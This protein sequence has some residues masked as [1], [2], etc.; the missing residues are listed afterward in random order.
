MTDEFTL[1]KQMPSVLR[2]RDF[3]LYTSRGRLVDLWQ[4]GGAAIL[5]HTPASVLREIKNTAERGLYAPFPHFLETRYFKAL[6]KIFPGRS[7]RLYAA[8]PPDLH[9][10]IKNGTAA[11]WRPFLDAAD[12]LN[13][14]E[15]IPVLIPVV[16]GIQLWRNG[17]PLGLCVLVI[18]QNFDK[19]I[20]LPPGDFLSPVLL[21]AATR[22]LYNLIASAP[23]RAKTIFPRIEKALKHGKD[24]NQWQRQGIY[25]T[26]RQFPAENEWTALFNRFLENGFLLPPVPSQPVI[27]PGTLSPGEEAKLAGLLS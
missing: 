1:L 8:P 6:L 27:L 14:N 18:D 7:F 3:R 23:Q 11:L 5:G 12:P 2:A 19:A 9:T 20:F 22:G 13:V 4:N 25:L 17:L 21:A 10:F 16:P 15:N 26:P 24:K